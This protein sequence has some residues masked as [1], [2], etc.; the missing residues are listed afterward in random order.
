M[1]CMKKNRHKLTSREKLLL[2]EA[3][4]KY[5]RELYLYVAFQTKNAPVVEDIVSETFALACEKIRVFKKHP[6]QKGWL[7]CAA[8]LKTLEMYR[9]LREADLISVEN[10]DE[11]FA[12]DLFPYADREWKLSVRDILTEEEYLRFRRYF[13]WGYSLREMAFLEGITENYMSV[14]LSRL[15]KKLRDIL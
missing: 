3:Y 10:M 2:S 15:R 11:E 1:E 14:K 9:R 7:L 12:A 5:H 8:H 4:H 6:N 13:I